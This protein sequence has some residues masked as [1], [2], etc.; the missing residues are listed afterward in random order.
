MG[1]CTLGL[2]GWATVFLAGIFMYIADSSSSSG[3]AV[4]AAECLFNSFTLGQSKPLDVGACWGTGQK[5]S[6]AGCSNSVTSR[7]F[8]VFCIFVTVYKFKESTGTTG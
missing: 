2:M 1:G 5:G 6:V 3:D 4:I 7:L 8:M